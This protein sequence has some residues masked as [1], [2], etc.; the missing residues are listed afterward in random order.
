VKEEAEG[1]SN[2]RIIE[3]FKKLKKLPAKDPLT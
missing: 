2:S 3:Y 1:H